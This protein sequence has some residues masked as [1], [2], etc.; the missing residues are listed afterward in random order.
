MTQQNTSGVHGGNGISPATGNFC[1][2]SSTSQKQVIANPVITINIGEI[3][4]SVFA[5][6]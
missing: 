1:A 4:L 5:Q 6:A 2:H 3:K